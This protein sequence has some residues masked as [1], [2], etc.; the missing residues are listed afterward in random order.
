MTDT[1]REIEQGHEA[2]FKL[3]EELRFKVRVAG[4]SCSG[5]GRPKSWGSTTAGPTTTRDR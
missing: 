4:T 5:C 3:D 1:F 2:K